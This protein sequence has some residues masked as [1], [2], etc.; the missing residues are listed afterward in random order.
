MLIARRLALLAAL[1]VPTLAPAQVSLGLK[2][3]YGVPAG[4]AYEQSG[5]GTFKQSGL[6]RGVVPIQVDASWRFTPALS[7]GL[8]YG[9]G[10]GRTGSKLEEL[11]STP[12]ASCDRPS[13]VRYGVQGA[14]TFSPL[15]QVE[16][17]MGL[18][19]GV[20]AA[21]FKVKNFVY[22]VIPGA[23]PTPLIADLE[24]TL[25]GWSA[26]VSGGADHRF[27]PNL[28]AGPFLA[29]GMGQYTVQHVTLSDQGTVAGG[30]VDSAKTH[31]WLS[32]GVRGRF[33]L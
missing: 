2:V 30:G 13:L 9:Y 10:F 32:F 15:A 5:F 25:R 17:W 33:D 27:S 31:Q 8:Y 3:G 23:P 18:S 16:P 21:S 12:S 20:E 28:L 6:A 29:Y 24:G 14:Y 1:V 26:E 11:C 22:G 19:A 4:D 7:A